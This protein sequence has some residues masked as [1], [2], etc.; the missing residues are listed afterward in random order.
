MTVR[1]TKSAS[2]E[3]GY[4][5]PPRRTQFRKGQSGNP[6][7][8][9]RGRPIEYV[10]EMALQEAYRTVIVKREDGAPCRCRPS[11]RSCAASSRAPPPATPGRN[12]PS[13]R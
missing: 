12:A 10:K 6:G 3:V 7:G 11:G 2:Y 8:R 9:P 5:K 1:Q 4:G 13:W